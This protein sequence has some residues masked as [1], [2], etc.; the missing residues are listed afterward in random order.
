MWPSEHCRKVKTKSRK[1]FVTPFFRTPEKIKE[2][3]YDSQMTNTCKVLALISR[4][5]H[6][7]KTV[8]G[9]AFGTCS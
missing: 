1:W 4:K 9:K 6:V 3:I 2:T 8:V 5:K 7:S